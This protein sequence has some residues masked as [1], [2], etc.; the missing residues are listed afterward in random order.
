MNQNLGQ[1]SPPV[2]GVGSVEL[3]SMLLEQALFKVFVVQ[4]S[5][6]HSLTVV[7]VAID[8]NDFHIGRLAGDHL[9]T[10]NFANSLTWIHYKHSQSLPR[11]QNC[12]N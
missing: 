5:L 6:D 2:D 12:K 3:D 8:S 7:K 1:N 11:M 10:L 9:L 4:K